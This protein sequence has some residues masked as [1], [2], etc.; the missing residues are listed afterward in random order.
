MTYAIVFD[1]PEA[2]LYAGRF[3]DAMGWA[4]TLKTA[5]LF[6]TAEAANNMRLNGCGTL[7]AEWGKV[8]TVA[9]GVPA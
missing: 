1:F 3:K 2:T 7:G 4:P 9:R 5:E 6:D 8:V